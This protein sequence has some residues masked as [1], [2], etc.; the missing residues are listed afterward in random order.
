M[1][2]AATVTRYVASVTD[3]T[4]VGSV[5]A[6][7]GLTDFLLLSQQNSFLSWFYYTPERGGR[8]CHMSHLPTIGLAA[9]VT[10]HVASVTDDTSMGSVWAGIGLTDL[11]FFFHN[12]TL[13]FLVSTIHLKGGG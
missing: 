5:W 7:I 12:K 9:T 4:S 10:S 2:L 1:A 8:M 3:D 6:G 11:F 13:F